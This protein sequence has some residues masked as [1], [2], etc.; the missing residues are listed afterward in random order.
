[1]LIYRT[2]LTPLFLQTFLLDK[3]KEFEISFSIRRD[4]EPY[5]LFNE[6]L[7]IV[8]VEMNKL[9]K[10]Y[11]DFLDLKEKWCYILRESG[12]IT[13]EE[14]RYLSK[15]EEIR[16]ALKHLQDLSRDNEL[17]Q[18]ALTEEL[19]SVSYRL[20]KAGWIE[21]GIQTGIKKGRTQGKLEARKQVVIDMLRKNFELSVVCELI[22][23][24]KKELLGLKK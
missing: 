11:E 24:S 19:N 2:P 22:G 12:E 1:M 4:K 14:S 8:I 21:F 3:H 23:L 13:K 10:S 9:K 20:D 5:E 6:D 15:D 17:Y 18:Q 7:R 16:M